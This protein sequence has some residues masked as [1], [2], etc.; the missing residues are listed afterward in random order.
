MM[1]Q[2]V[3]G[4]VAIPGDLD[5]PAS[6]TPA[7][8]GIRQLVLITADGPQQID[9]AMTALE[10]ARAA[11]VERIVLISAML[12]GETP[13]LSFGVNHRRIEELAA[14]TGIP[15]QVLRPSF[16]VQTLGM[17]ADP[18]RKFGRLLVPV[19]TGKVAF[20]D[21]ADIAA[22]VV[23][24]LDPGRPVSG[25]KV[26]TG[27]QALGFAE[28]AALI[29]AATGRKIVHTAL[30]IPVMAALL[31]TA[32]GQSLWFTGRLIAMFRALEA[33]KEATV[34]PDLAELIGR[35]PTTVAACLDRERQLF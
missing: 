24:C 23:P 21:V 1:R 8:A 34:S 32:G 35:P 2:P 10:A 28:V 26:L 15:V 12:A 3:A 7:F 19:P 29:S 13:P 20:V 16:F 4:M 22:A 31:A 6:L 17:F 14:A 30:P 33:G 9:Q 27:A 18:V 5:D 25:P 11:A